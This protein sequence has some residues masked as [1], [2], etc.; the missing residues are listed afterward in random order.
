MSYY[1]TEYATIRKPFGFLIAQNRIEMDV[2][3][4]ARPKEMEQLV[5]AFDEL[6]LEY[7]VRARTWTDEMPEP[8]EYLQP[9]RA[10][11]RQ[12]AVVHRA[13]SRDA[14]KSRQ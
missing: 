12:S 7:R 2:K 9:R 14:T 6:L 10:G 1:Y 11:I 5:E 13:V 8:V 3:Y 4:M